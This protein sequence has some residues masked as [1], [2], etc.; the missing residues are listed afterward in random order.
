MHITSNM[1]LFQ[2]FSGEYSTRIQ[3]LHFGDDC[4]NFSVLFRGDDA[5]IQHALNDCHGRSIGDDTPAQFFTHLR[6]SLLR[7]SE[8]HLREQY[9][10]F[11]RWERNVSPQLKQVC[12]YTF[13]RTI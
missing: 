7:D 3:A 11:A 9:W 1:V 6:T 13:F 4:I 2:R 10:L 8:K 5:I 12:A